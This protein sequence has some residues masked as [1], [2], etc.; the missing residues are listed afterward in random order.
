VFTGIAPGRVEVGALPKAIGCTATDAT[1]GVGPG[2]CVVAG[3]STAPGPHTL[4]ATATDAA[5]L[6]STSTLAYV[7]TRPSLGSLQIPTSLRSGAKAKFSFRLAAPA[8]LRFAV[9]RKRSGRKVGKRCLASTRANR[10]KPACVRFVRLG[11]ITARGKKGANSLSFSGRVA[12][13]K[14][15][16][17]TYR[18]SVVVIVGTAT[19]KVQT[20]TL[21]VRR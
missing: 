10:R 9:E 7:V 15:A 1:S 13:R 20:R 11:N 3:R 19:S 21:T 5:G 8:A 16:P 17:G 2:G 12:G 6:R 4:S 18:I 14:L